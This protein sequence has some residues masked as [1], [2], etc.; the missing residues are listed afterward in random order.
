MVSDPVEHV[1]L[2]L[3]ELIEKGC[4]AVPIEVEMP[5]KWWFGTVIDPRTGQCFTY[6]GAWDFIAEKL[7]EGCKLQ[8]KPLRK[9][10]TDM[11]YVL[12]VNTEQ[13][14]IYIKLQLGYDRVIG[15]SFHYSGD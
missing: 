10:P 6:R 13:R 7:R 2:R 12:L 4:I 15:R 5:H 14:D 1:R 9:P 3:I 11:G 8:E